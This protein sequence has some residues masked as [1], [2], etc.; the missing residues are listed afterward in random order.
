MHGLFRRLTLSLTDAAQALASA[1]K[2][3]DQADGEERAGDKIV[4]MP[5]A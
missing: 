4:F 2:P 1:R 5:V 3:K